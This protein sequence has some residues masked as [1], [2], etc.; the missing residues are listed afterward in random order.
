MA[1]VAKAKYIRI[2]PRKMRVVANQIRGKGV[3]GAIDY[4][5]FCKRSAATP[6][7]KVVKSA[8]ANAEQKGGIDVDNLYVKT[9]LIDEGPTM[10][11]WLPRARGMATKILKRSSH[12]SIELEEK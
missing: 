9:I 6:I 1:V 4:L 11:R 10:R 7:L 8:L 5:N 3:Q 2:T 12:V